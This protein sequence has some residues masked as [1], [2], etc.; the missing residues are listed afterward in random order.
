MRSCAWLAVFLALIAPCGWA[1][2]PPPNLVRNGDCEQWQWREFTEG[3]RTEIKALL[4]R[5]TKLADLNLEIRGPL[6]RGLV[7]YDEIQG[8]MVEGPEA[9]HGRS[10][11]LVSGDDEA[12]WGYHYLLTQPLQPRAAYA[13]DLYL[14]GQ[15]VLSLRA[16]LGGKEVTTGAFAWLGYPELVKFTATETWQRF[17]GTLTI[18]DLGTPQR[19]QDDANLALS[20]APHSALLLDDLSLRSRPDGGPTP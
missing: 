16:L 13:Y 1:Q 20:L 2:E 9:C 3:Q 19:P 5:G 7:G 6:Y 14:K 12:Q 4:A 11:R 8:T 15:G 10:L 18:P 17:Q